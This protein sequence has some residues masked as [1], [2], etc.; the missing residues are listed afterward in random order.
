MRALACVFA[1]VCLVGRADTLELRDGRVITGTFES[2]DKTHIRFRPDHS[3]RTEVYLRSRVA[4][5]TLNTTSGPSTASTPVGTVAATPPPPMATVTPEPSSSSAN[6]QAS[7]NIIPAGT[8]IQVR[9]PDALQLDASHI[10]DTYSVALAEPIVVNGNM[11]A[12]KGSG[13]TLQVTGIAGGNRLTGTGDVMV[14]LVSFSGSTGQTYNTVTSEAVVSDRSHTV[15]R[16]QHIQVRPGAVL[17][18]TL[19]Q[20]VVL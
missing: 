3:R 1:V 6:V 5:V 9:V 16:G 18:F 17:G 11:V 8:T 13:A 20:N 14:Q 7:G 10:G 19:Q 15:L 2:A 4:H 12:A